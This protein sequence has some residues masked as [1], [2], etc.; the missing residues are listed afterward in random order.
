M[1]SAPGRSVHAAYPKRRAAMINVISKVVLMS[2]VFLTSKGY[3][4]ATV[5]T[6]ES[7]F[8][9]NVGTTIFENF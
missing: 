5:Y 4:T 1:P 8:L 9:S 3:A 7:Q 2:M 6:D